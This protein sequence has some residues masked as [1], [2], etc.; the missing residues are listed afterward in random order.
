MR[1]GRSVSFRQLQTS[2]RTRPWRLGAQ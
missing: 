1:R 2:L